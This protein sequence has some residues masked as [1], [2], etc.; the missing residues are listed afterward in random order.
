M[1]SEHFYDVI[2]NTH[3]RREASCSN[4]F[5]ATD[6]WK[7]ENVTTVGSNWDFHRRIIQTC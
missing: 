7:T 4:L 2:S 6:G 1:H 5:Q 3:L